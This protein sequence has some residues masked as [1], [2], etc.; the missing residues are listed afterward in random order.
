MKK[1]ALFFFILFL[2]A[3]I[4]LGIEASSDSLEIDFFYSDSCPHCAAEEE[5]LDYIE[6]E[7][8]QVEINRYLSSSNREK[9]VDMCREYEVERYIGLVPITFV[10]DECFLGFDNEKGVG[11]KIENSIKKQLEGEGEEKEDD[12][13]INLPIVGEIDLSS[14]TLPLQAVIL[15]FFD[16]FNV[17]SLGALVLILG[18]VLIL[19]S[20]AKIFVFGG[21][22][23]LVTALVYGLLIVLWY[24]LFYVLAPV[25]NIMNIFV[26]ILGLLGGVYFLKQF[27]RYRK[28]GPACDVSSGVVS[29]MSSKVK[30]SIKESGG[31]WG[32]LI[33]VLIFAVVV[34]VVEFPCSAV[35]PVF[36]AGALAQANLP[37]W[38]YLL[39]IAIFVFF[40]MLDEIVVFLIAVLTMNIKIA[41]SKAMVWITL[42]EA[43]V[44][45][46]LG[47]YYLFGL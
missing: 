18:L 27:V 47:F 9:L 37:V 36:F 14:Y 31:F 40:Y 11:A 19:K 10:G 21:L 3:S 42:V 15:G 25:L 33:S 44:L 43:I 8:P 45:F 2:F 46:G 12:E 16:G 28:Y 1:V 13:A 32:V 4:P 6:E 22:F 38:T 23:I 24:Q 7:Y 39:Y 20:R 41:S 34:T 5:F 17:C 29:K 30:E 26:G 35:I